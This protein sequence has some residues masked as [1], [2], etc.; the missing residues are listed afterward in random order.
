MVFQIAA[1]GAGAF[2]VLTL[3]A[4]FFYP[5]GTIL[6]A[7]TQGYRFFENFFSD[8]GFTTAHNGETNPISAGL[9]FVALC[10][11]G[12]SLILFFFAFWR[13]FQA[14]LPLR[15]LSFAGTLVGVMAGI[16]FIGVACTPADIRMGAHVFFVTWAFRLF[17]LAVVFYAAAIFTHPTYP[18]RYGWGMIGFMVCLV[19][20][21][22]L[23][24]L[25]P[26]AFESTLGQTIQV[27]GQKAIVYC[28]IGSVLV[29][30]LGARKFI[31]S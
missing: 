27:V 2:I 18:R 21:V 15:I 7:T 3:I 24:E 9:F 29:Q 5:G 11:A 16:C 8:L 12:L 28:S 25:G 4:M 31:T 30:A 13:F 20:Y 14:A 17:P 6:D 10:L 23:L 26:D 19:G 22:L 1:W